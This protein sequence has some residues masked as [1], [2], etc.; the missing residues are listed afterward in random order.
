MRQ[1]YRKTQRAL[2]GGLALI[3]ACNLAVP[4]F[5]QTAPVAPIAADPSPEKLK[6][7][8]LIVRVYLDSVRDDIVD[9]H[10]QLSAD[11]PIFKIPPYNNPVVADRLP[12]WIR[13]GRHAGLAAFADYRPQLEPL[14]ARALASHET[15]AELHAGEQFMI[16]LGGRYA[17]R[18]FTHEY[19]LRTLG[20]TP[21]PPP[22]VVTKPGAPANPNAKAAQEMMAAVQ[23]R[24][25]AP[26]PADEAAA[27]AR[28]KS[29]PEGRRFLDDTLAVQVWLK[30]DATDVVGIVLPPSLIHL[31]QDLEASEARRA[32]AAPAPAPAMALGVS[33]VHGL[34]AAIDDKAWDRFTSLTT[35]AAAKAASGATAKK[36]IP[37]QDRWVRIAILSGF[38]LLRKD[39]GVIEQTIG[40]GLAR[41]FS[42][43]DLQAMSDFAN[44]PAP[45]YFV[46]ATLAKLDGA[47]DAAPPPQEVTDSLQKFG[48]V[49]LSQHLTERYQKDQQQVTAIGMDMVMP[50]VAR[51]MRR[52]GEEIG[53]FEA[54]R[55]AARR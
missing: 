21:P 48:Q 50:I 3:A 8:T 25:H 31:S 51:W 34:F 38:D 41:L 26:L 29:T 32:A 30:D 27:L 17:N 45:A 6:A 7:A 18:I 10:G 33:T 39:Q 53:A 35:D 14:L 49:N 23:D 40:R 19:M 37:D 46:K 47:K 28:L 15:L 20:K 54:E 42:I 44:G 2:A 11:N 36:V 24:I 52:L 12:D 22:T 5:S 4:A 1:P 13:D 55:V 9:E 43:E 16:G